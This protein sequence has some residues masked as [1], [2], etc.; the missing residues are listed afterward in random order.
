MEKEGLVDREVNRGATVRR[1]S[2]EEALQ[3]TE[4][5]RLLEGLVAER[6]AKVA[7]S[8][9][10]TELRTIIES[11]RDAVT[12]ERFALYSELNGVLHRRL[13]EISGH[14]VACDLIDNLRNRAASHE[15]RLAL[16][17]G[18]PAESLGQHEA[19]VD[20]IVAGDGAAA[21][22]AMHAHLRSVMDVLRRWE[23]AELQCLSR[24]LTKSERTR[25]R[26]LDAA[27]KVFREQGYANAR[28]SDI[29]ALAGMQTG[30]LYYHFDSARTW[31]RRSSASASRRRGTT[32]ARPSMRYRPDATALDRLAAAIRAHTLAVL[33]ISDYASAQARIVGQ[34]PP[35]VRKGH[36]VHQRKYGAYWN[37][38][39]EA[40]VAA[41]RSSPRRRFVRG[42]HARARRPQ[43]DG[44]V[45]HAQA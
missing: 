4:V 25:Q 13:R 14:A 6:A 5:R 43:L 18:R 2:L 21:E 16:M 31:W 45:V 44:R 39:I 30:S 28:L 3:I 1:V 33:E 15:F 36:L 35:E 17:P 34:V 8:A 12:T 42:A 19:I 37:E 40:A 38:L 32:C 29:A 41:G 10:H 20:A 23:P 24:P 11:M 27:A 26:I 9:D 7:T 22:A